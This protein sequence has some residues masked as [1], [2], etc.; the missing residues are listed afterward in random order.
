MAASRHQCVSN[1]GGELEGESLSPRW[2]DREERRIAFPMLLF[3]QQP[4]HQY[5]T[6]SDETGKSCG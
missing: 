6:I 5:R 1:K 3:L 2:A 4:H